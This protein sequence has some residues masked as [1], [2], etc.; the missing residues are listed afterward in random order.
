MD[1]PKRIVERGYDAI[2]DRYLAWSGERP[3]RARQRALELV[4]AELPADA[5]ILELGCGAGIPMTAALA[6]ARKPASE[7]S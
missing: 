1:E 6:M 3:S 7:A 2:A 4:L 5:E